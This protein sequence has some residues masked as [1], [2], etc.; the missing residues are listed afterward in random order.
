MSRSPPPRPPWISPEE[1]LIDPV[2]ADSGDLIEIERWIEARPE[3]V[4]AYFTDP[5]RFLRWQGGDASIEP[6]PGG[7]FRVS[8][9][10][11]TDGV[12][13]GEFLEVV[14]PRR[15]VFTWAWGGTTSKYPSLATL[16]AGPSVV[17]ISLESQRGGT[18]LR[19]RQKPQGSD[20]AYRAPNRA[21][22]SEPPVALP[23]V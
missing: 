18:L 7:S 19:L 5:A 2:P 8:V 1:D 4:F 13:Q 17:E 9:G 6:H 23:A 15:L 3:T 20:N 14:A 16:L 21:A 11:P 10:G 22:S 12:V